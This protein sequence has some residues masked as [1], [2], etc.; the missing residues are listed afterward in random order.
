MHGG[1][2]ERGFEEGEVLEG[3]GLVLV[4]ADNVLE[5]LR[6]GERGGS[7]GV[8]GKVEAGGP[9]VGRVGYV[10]GVCAMGSMKLV[11]NK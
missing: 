9:V 6:R 1:G 5:H 8:A 3:D 11:E 10:E 7:G 2:L 4:V